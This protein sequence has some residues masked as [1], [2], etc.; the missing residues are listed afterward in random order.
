[1]CVN[2][3]ITQQTFLWYVSI[4]SVMFMRYAES[5]YYNFAD[6]SVEKTSR[7]LQ[8]QYISSRFSALDDWPPY[9]PKH[10]TALAFIHYKERQT[11]K[12]IISFSN[13]SKQ[14]AN[15]GKLVSAQHEVDSNFPN[16]QATQQ[17]NTMK[18]ISKLFASDDKHSAKLFLI[19]GAPGIGKTILSKE[20]AYQWANNFLLHHKKFLFLVHLRTVSSSKLCSV[21]DFVKHALHSKEAAAGFGKYFTENSGKDLAVILDGYDELSETDRKNSFITDLIKRRVLS[22]CLLIITSRPS[23]SLPLRDIA[24]CRIEVVGFTEEDRLNYI[25]SA[26]SD[27]PEKV[28]ALQDYLQSNPTINALCYIPLNMTILLCLSDNGIDYL[29]KTQTDMY[30][31]FIGMT[32]IRFLEKSGENIPD[33]AVFN[34]EAL[35]HPHDVVFK[36]LSRFAFEALKCDKL[37]FKLTEIQEI[38]P[39]L[40]KISSNWNGLGLLNSL[41]YVEDGNK[42]VTYHF[43]HFSIQE[44]MAAYHIS[45]LPEKKQLKLLK[46]TFWSVDYYNT[47]IMYVGITGGATFPF[48]HFLSGNPLQ[49]FTHLFKTGISKKF[50]HDKI[51]CLHIFQCLAEAQG[52]DLLSSLGSLFQN[53]EIDLSDQTLLPRDLNT[54]G[55]FL[56][57]SNNKHWKKLNLSRC[58]MDSASLKILFEMFASKDTQVTIDRVDLSYNQLKISF[59]N[60]LLKLVKTWKATEFICIDN[61]VF[62]KENTLRIA[63]FVEPQS[64]DAMIIKSFLIGSFLYGYNLN[65]NEMFDLLGKAERIRT[66]YL[67]S[68]RWKFSASKTTDLLRKQLLTNVHIFKSYLSSEVL[69]ALCSTISQCLNPNLIIDDPNLSDEFSDEIMTLLSNIISNGN[70]LVVSMNKIQGVINTCSLSSELSNLELLNLIRRIRSLCSNFVP[71]VTSWDEN[72]QWYGYKSDGIIE[73]FINVLLLSKSVTD[74]KIALVENHT[75][76]A[77]AIKWDKIY[78]FS[79]QILKFAYLSNC[80]NLWKLLFSIQRFKLEELFI[81]STDNI[82]SDDVETI[83]TICYHHTSVVV[84][85]KDTLG[86][87]NPTSKQLAMAHKLEPSVTSWKFF[88]CNLNVDNCK[89]IA[90]LLTS[91]ELLDKIHFV[92]CNIGINEIEILSNDLMTEQCTL[93]IQKLHFT[94]SRLVS[95]T[96]L[97]K[98][99]SISNVIIDDSRY[100]FCV[101][102]LKTLQNFSSLS[103]LHIQLSNV[104]KEIVDDVAAFILNNKNLRMINLGKSN[105]QTSGILIIAK[106]LQNISSLTELYINNNNITEEAADDIAAVIVN[107]NKLEKL[108]IGTNKIQT[109]GMLKIAKALQNISSLTELYVNDNNITDEAAGDIAAVILSNSTLQ[110]LNLSGNKFLMGGMLTI[111]NTLRNISSLTNLYINDN[112]ITEEVANDIAAVILNNTKLH[113]L[114]VHG[115]NFKAVG[116]VTVAKNVFSLSELNIGWNNITEEAANDIAAVLQNNTELRIFNIGGNKLQTVGMIKI[117]KALQKISSLSELDIGWNSI[118]EEAADDIAAVIVNNSKL[119]VLNLSSNNLKAVGM[120]KV[121]KALQKNSLLTELHIND[122]KITKEAADDI[123]AVI[124]NNNVQVLDLGLNHFKALGMIKILQALQKNFS[125]CKLKIEWNNITEEAAHDIAAVMNN[126]NLQVLHLGVNHFRDPGTIE[127]AKSLQKLSS[128]TGLCINCNDVTEKAAEN[129]AAAIMNNR[130]LQILQLG[131]NN[132]KAAGIIPIA[133]ALQNINSLT[134]LYINSNNVSENAADDIA[135]VI[136][137]NKLQILDLSYND[138]KAAGTIKIAKALQKVNSIIEL[139]INNNN[140]TDE[141]A[142]DIAAVILSNHNLFIIDLSGNML[143]RTGEVAIKKAAQIFPSFLKL[144]ITSNEFI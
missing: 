55:F 60:R 104:S 34:L 30:K 24:N 141:A 81:H 8:T 96:A 134:A 19:E 37:V 44:F 12:K 117:A 97:V 112:D 71:V 62:D 22:K 41:T 95:H 31:R 64:S 143:Q 46:D 102:A 118:S 108:D 79:N 103:G 67:I 113:V 90:I 26:L 139:Y 115:N 63:Q 110:T 20:I 121:A 120:I 38:C 40:T 85:T 9:Q 42:I 140:I 15:K 43:L 87:C 137:N 127:I 48:K 11:D 61:L 83:L 13:F 4:C 32:I 136:L 138:F 47:W 70:I 89:L 125:L 73:T 52:S 53:Q 93:V 98:V 111:A 14:L 99:I 49:V 23:A 54:L 6:L 58:N 142:D 25:N 124:V 7:A 45:T 27:S 28:T 21:E 18:N 56:I 91:S 57:R 68:C 5:V 50:L 77:C 72:L 74:L 135:V 131:F 88:H 80:G 106:S 132:F 33:A 92:G 78:F 3:N 126:N 122:N 35:P 130:K 65:E 107:N 101:I 75:L 100:A 116:I 144:I 2:T 129:I 86:A 94:S 17:S 105:L 123:A 1:M 59:I 36:E 16:C 114:D 128:L 29:P 82:T 119:Q 66:M 133:K 51:K 69:R 109:S 10:Y 84:V 76:I 39:S